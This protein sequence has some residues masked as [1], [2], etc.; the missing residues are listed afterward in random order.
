MNAT[1]TSA[2]TNLAKSKHK[3]SIIEV[4]PNIGQVNTP[5]EDEDESDHSN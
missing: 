5:A 2:F 1:A 4:I 3:A